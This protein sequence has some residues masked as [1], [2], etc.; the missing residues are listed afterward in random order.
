MR[1]AQEQ[2]DAM[3]SKFSELHT[4]LE[5]TRPFEE[6]IKY[7]QEIERNVS[8]LDQME[9]VTPCDNII[10]IGSKFR[11]CVVTDGNI[12]TDDYILS[13]SDVPVKGYRVI[14]TNCPLAK[15]LMGK[16]VK[17]TEVYDVS[18]YKVTATV[19]EIYKEKAKIKT[20]I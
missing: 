9:A 12:T 5:E 16:T 18:G 3:S 17:D 10:G 6:K 19:L 14:L 7:Q 11:A 2:I 20:I 13:E 15:A 1:V 8:L 4:K